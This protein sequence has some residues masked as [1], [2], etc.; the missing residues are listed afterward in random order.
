M[1]ELSIECKYLRYREY[2]FTVKTRL[3]QLPVASQKLKLG[4]PVSEAYCKG[5]GSS[6]E[7]QEQCLSVCKKKCLP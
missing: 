6:I 7:T 5:C 2:R 4:K 1:G 3:N